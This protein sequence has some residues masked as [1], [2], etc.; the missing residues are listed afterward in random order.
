MTDSNRKAREI[1]DKSGSFVLTTHVAPDGDAI[2]SVMAFGNYLNA[3]GKKVEIINHSPTPFNLKFM[4]PENKIRV[5]QDD[6]AHCT[7]LI[8][9]SDVVAILDTNEYHRTR[10]MENVIGESP[11]LK[12][13][14]DHHTGIREE[15]FDAVVSETDCAATCEILYDFISSDSES[16]IT[17][18][19]A[20]ALYVGIMTDT[21]SF[22]HPRTDSRV[23]R[24][25][26]E[27]LDKGA[28]PVYLYD[29]I[30]NRV[31]KEMMQLQ[32]AFL[33]GLEFHQDGTVV[34]G[35]VMQSD[36]KKYGLSI[37]HIEGFTSLLMSIEGIKVGVM[38]VELRDNIKLSFRS[39]GNIPAN[40]M[41]IHFGG[42][43]HFNAGG[44]NVN[45]AKVEELKPKVLDAV[46][47][48]MNKV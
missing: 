33:S 7:G 15:M 14:I 10:S 46:I 12:I 39:K 45:G 13:C 25:C 28:D 41:A 31:S 6:P 35:T 17:K 3:K 43:G 38:F 40:E 8:L 42:G 32:A 1:I 26:A 48:Y 29:E 5:F 11:A 27:L 16:Y 22:R 23:F 20:S 2:G 34:L 36:F 19:I 21:G 47:K 18:E 44:A 30:C 9:N 4:D 24:I 37:D